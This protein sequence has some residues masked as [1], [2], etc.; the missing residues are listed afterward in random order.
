MKVRLARVLVSSLLLVF[1]FSSLATAFCTRDSQCD[2]RASGLD[3]DS[4]NPYG[5]CIDNQCVYCQDGIDNDGDGQ[6]DCSDMSVR[7]YELCPAARF[8]SCSSGERAVCHSRDSSYGPSSSLKRD[9]GW[10]CEAIS[11]P[12]TPCPGGSSGC[13]SRVPAGYSHYSQGDAWCRYYYSNRPVCAMQSSTT[14]RSCRVSVSSNSLSAGSRTLVTVSYQNLVSSPQYAFIDCGNGRQT[15]AYNCDGVSGSCSAYCYYPLEGPF[16]VTAEPLRGTDCSSA[17]VDVFAAGS[18]GD[19]NCLGGENPSSCPADCGPGFFCGDGV[20]S[21][22]ETQKSC[23]EDCGYPVLQCSDGTPFDSCSS[24]KPLFCDNGLLVQRPEECGCPANNT[25]ENG[26]CVSSLACSNG[27]KPGECALQKPY[28]CSSSLQLEQRASLCG[29]PPNQV[30]IGDS[31]VSQNYCGFLNVSVDSSRSVNQGQTAS[32]SISVRNTGPSSQTVYLSAG[33]AQVDLQFDDSIL[34]IPTGQSKT[35]VLSAFTSDVPGGSYS[36]P[37]EVATLSCRSDYSLGLQVNAPNASLE[38]CCKNIGE[39]KA[40]LTPNTRQIARP[41]DTVEYHVLLENPSNEKVYARLSSPDNP[42]ETTTDFEEIEVELGPRESK[43]V[44]IAVTIPPGTPG[45]TFQLLFL[46]KYGAACCMR[47]I[48]LPAQVLCTFAPS[49]DLELFREPTVACTVV[50]HG[51]LVSHMIGLKNAGEVTGPY[52]L[53]LS[54]PQSARGT[55]SL[56]KDYFEL[57]QG[58][59]DWFNVSFAPSSQVSL[60][61]YYYSL[62]VKYLSFTLL[63]RQYCFKVEEFSDAELILPDQVQAPNCYTSAF[64]FKA[65]NRGSVGTNF[66]ITAGDTRGLRVLIEPHSFNIAAGQCKSAHLI[67]VP[68]L[69]IPLGDYVIPLTLRSSKLSKAYSVHATIISGLSDSTLFKL[70]APSEFEVIQGQPQFFTVS[71]ENMRNNSAANAN[72]SVE[73]LPPGWATVDAPQDISPSSTKQF[74]IKFLVSG[75]AGVEYPIA[76]VARA[77]KEFTSTNATLR[78][79]QPSKELD[80]SYTMTPVVEAGAVKEV[81]LRLT[82]KNTGNSFASN[83]KPLVA[84]SGY[85]VNSSPSSVSL[86]PGASQTMTVRIAAASG[87]ADPKTVS[88]QLQSAEGGQASRPVEIPALSQSSKQAGPAS[89]LGLDGLPWKLIAIVLLLV[90]IFAILAREK[91]E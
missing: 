73:G 76:I 41:G 74:R 90:A 35:A 44:S 47:E 19:G 81:V 82:V 25:L 30:Q 21:N 69:S 22:G 38:E 56:S 12:R 87:Q 52:R 91:T 71:V 80:Y 48:P 61:T 39:M 43:I 37:L 23:P 13:V 42:F 77:G 46:V 1:L 70:S 31:C 24:T 85:S 36:I 67:L 4:S 66:S 57:K 40:S 8:V 84:A 65:C 28:Y 68:S 32:Y 29:C 11:S 5:R 53:E 7:G 59:V 26:Q 20:C 60:G 51:Q 55:A 27:A 72:V 62:T 75:N 6:R 64:E 58:E 79:V 14:T 16:T 17:Q 2:C 33:S 50:K 54:E 10:K 88:L 63:K 83:V 34:E 78:I 9:A 89:A 18:C 3:C 86:A 15:A 49:A 45:N